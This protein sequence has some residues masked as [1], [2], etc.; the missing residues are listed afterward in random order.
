LSFGAINASFSG[1]AF[2]VL[3]YT[4]ILQ[5][6]DLKLQRDSLELTRA[7]LSRTALAQEQAQ[8]W[9]HFQSQSSK[10]NATII[11]IN[12]LI[13]H[14]SNELREM[15]GIDYENDDPRKRRLNEVE[16]KLAKLIG[17]L[18]E[19]H[20]NLESEIKFRAN[21]VAPPVIP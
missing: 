6:E 12:T 15:E 14:Y 5:R 11:T 18:D 13:T 1:M 7:E 20:Q 3:A 4:M 8:Q 21:H 9:L 19:F 2:L 17:I 16:G 10:D